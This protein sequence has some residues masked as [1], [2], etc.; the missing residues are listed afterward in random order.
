MELNKHSWKTNG[1]EKKSEVKKEIK[2]IW[3]Q[4][5]MN[6]E[7][8]KTYDMKQ[9]QFKMEVYSNKHLY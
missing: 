6:I 9:K 4:M 3:R 2:N 8:T 1:W 7:L 5:K